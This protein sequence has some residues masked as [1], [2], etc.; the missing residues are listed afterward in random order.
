EEAYR[1]Q[2]RGGKGLIAMN[3]NNKT[4]DMCCMKMANG[5]EDVMMVRDDGTVIRLPIDQINVISRNTQGVRLMRIA[6]GTKVAGVALVPH[7]ES[8]EDTET[9]ETTETNE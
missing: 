2:R 1:T 4:G 6:D 7:D 9:V 3:I 8:E 5:D